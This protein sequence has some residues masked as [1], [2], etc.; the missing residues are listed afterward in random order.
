MAY[1]MRRNRRWR[2]TTRALL[3]S[4]VSITRAASRGISSSSS[5]SKRKRKATRLSPANSPLKSSERP[6]WATHW[7][8]A[9]R[10]LCRRPVGGFKTETGFHDSQETVNLPVGSRDN[11]NCLL[12]GDRISTVGSLSISIKKNISLSISYIR[13]CEDTRTKP[14]L[15]KKANSVSTSSPPK[16]W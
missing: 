14:N 1:K 5:R 4:L 16:S 9:L 3:F 7:A 11:S 10:T 2:T 15:L 8:T 13:M 6:L 12:L